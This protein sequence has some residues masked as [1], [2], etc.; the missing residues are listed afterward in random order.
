[1]SLLL[2]GTVMT[3]TAPIS[4]ASPEERSFTP[5]DVAHEEFFSEEEVGEEAFDEDAMVERL[6]EL[7][8]QELDGEQSASGEPDVGPGEVASHNMEHLSNVP[9]NG[10]LQ[11]TGSDIAFQGDYAYVGNYDGFTVY[12][13]ADPANPEQLVQVHC[14]GPQNDVSVYKD[15]LILSVDARMEDDTCG[16][17][18]TGDTQDYW[19]GLRVFD[20]SDPAEP[21]YVKAVE[22]KCGSH[23]NS[24]APAMHGNV[25][26]V[27]VSSYSPN[28]AL[29]NCQPP[30]DLISV[31]KIPV[32]APHAAKVTSE[33]VLFPDGGYEGDDRGGYTETS[34]C[35]DITTY[36]EHDLAAGAC[37]GD[38]ILMDIS[39]RE[40]P[41]VISQVRDVEN[42][43]FWHSATFN[44]DASKVV[45]TDELG[46]GGWATCTEEFGETLGANAIYDIVDGEL[47]FASY[48]KIPRINSENENCVAH[49][50]SLIPVQGRDLMV[51]SW[52]QGGISVFDF[53]DSA[54]PE[55]VAWFDRGEGISDGGTWS[56]YYYNGFVYSSDLSIGFDTFQLD[57]SIDGDARTDL[58]E[59][60]PQGQESF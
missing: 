55:E 7:E 31:V 35:H 54:N 59:L 48:Y 50:G 1:M 60:N 45:F 20:I 11:S 5:E 17:D 42:F 18:R 58:Q 52:Y 2:A 30:H 57:D 43:A 53:T 19:E 10:P 15:I 32:N 56:S 51:Q 33:P 49:N 38:G 16:A 41:E 13:L 6:S 8:G 27:Y 21:E 29:A 12:D 44:N 4:A 36:I 3:L 37:M 23:T 26:Y 34:G 14:P 47:E 28:P 9:K 39:D 46:G 22:T 25:L 40:N 24:L